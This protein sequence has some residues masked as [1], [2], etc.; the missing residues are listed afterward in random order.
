MVGNKID[1]DK[2]NRDEFRNFAGIVFISAANRIGIE[3]L[4]ERLMEQISLSSFRT[5]N[6]IVTNIRHYE[7]LLHT[8]DALNRVLQ[9]IGNEITGDLLAQDIRAAL[10]H[11]GEITGEITTD[12][13][14]GNIFSK[15]CIGK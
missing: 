5:G 1:K 14:L 7:S 9:G 15:F 12:D 13:L 11:L 10:H 8:R 6:T 3:E 4:K 2:K